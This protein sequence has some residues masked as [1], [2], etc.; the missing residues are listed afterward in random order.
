MPAASGCRERPSTTPAEAAREAEPPP[1]VPAEGFV[2]LPWGTR[3]YLE[4][5]FGGASARL[6]WPS[7]A[8]PPWPTTGFVAR[9]VGQREGFIEIAPIMPPTA[10][11][12]C[13]PLLEGEVFDVRL[14]V[15][16][17]SLA[18]VVARD[19]EVTL[20]DGTTLSLRPGALAQPVPDD[21]RGRWAISAGGIRVRAE[22]PDDATALAYAAPRAMPM[23]SERSFQLPEGRPFSFDGLPVE[24]E[25]G[26]GQDVAI[27]STSPGEDHHTVELMSPC[28]Q[29]T[30]RSTMVPVSWNSGFNHIEFGLGAPEPVPADVL[31]AVGLAEPVELDAPIEEGFVTVEGVAGEPVLVETVERKEVRQA[32]VE[33]FAGE[34]GILGSLVGGPLGGAPV[35]PEHVF[36]EGAP[37]YLSP[38]GPVAGTLSGMRVFSED[39]WVA[40]DRLCFHTGFGSRFDPVL[41]VCLPGD[42]ARPRNPTVD[43]HDFTSSVVRPQAVHVTGALDEAA[44]ARALR[45]NRSDLRRCL[46][47]ALQSLPSQGEVGL[48][49]GLKLDGRGAV[50]EV[51]PRLSPQTGGLWEQTLT[52]CTAAA[53]KR[54]VLPAP[55]DERP[56]EVVLTVRI[57]LR[58]MGMGFGFGRA[59]VLDEAGH[60]ALASLAL[61]HD[62]R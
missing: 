34:V 29:F 4:P 52:S 46:H 30:V 51:T 5:R 58:G 61:A 3:T 32:V 44:V 35:R 20:D 59:P 23:P 8:I 27:V 48:A 17:W 49:L 57:E 40:G 31:D 13:G 26:F 14:Y 56:A 54:W 28:A 6:G 18:P 2:V 33:P 43:V 42:E 21:P 39:G 62:D 60:D 1:E 41:P 15:S 10:E 24:L 7:M 55:A 11:L 16:P 50:T 19:V 22:L 9:V 25:L 45:R 12:H 37:V 38:A 36:E 47:E 53:A